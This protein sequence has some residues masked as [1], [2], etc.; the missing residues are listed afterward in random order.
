MATTAGS[1]RQRARHAVA[2]LR[3]QRGA[4]VEPSSYTST[5]AKNGFG[6]VLEAVIQGGVVVIT[7]HD[8]PKAVMLPVE[9]FNALAGA[10]QGTLDTLSHEF[11]QL[12]ARLQTPKARA[13]LRTAFDASPKALGRVARAAARRRG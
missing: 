11:D 9:E 7:K 4:R 10:R 2:A 13:G 3:N 6:Q 12:L 8:H 5:Q 1:R